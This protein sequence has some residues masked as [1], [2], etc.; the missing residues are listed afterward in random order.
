M[1]MVHGSFC[2]CEWQLIEYQQQNWAKLMLV[3]KHSC[4][5]NSCVILQES[6]GWNEKRAV[7]TGRLRSTQMVWQ[8]RFWANK[9]CKILSTMLVF[10]VIRCT[11]IF[12][13]KGNKQLK[14]IQGK[15]YKGSSQEQ[16]PYW[17]TQADKDPNMSHP[18]VYH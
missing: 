10:K 4:T 9:T 13:E 14:L 5:N 2:P 1:I 11:C 7:Q 3:I 15:L 6:S 8:I 18:R 17:R 12:L 16:N